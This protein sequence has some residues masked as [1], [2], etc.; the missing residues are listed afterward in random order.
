MSEDGQRRLEVAPD[1]IRVTD[2]WWSTD[3]TCLFFVSTKGD[4]HPG[5][6]RGLEVA[7]GEVR[8]VFR[9]AE[10][11]R[12][13]SMDSAN[14]WIACTRETNVSPPKLAVIDTRNGTMRT[15]T[16]LNPEFGH[17]KLNSGERISG[18]NQYGEDWFG[19]LVKPAGFEEGKRYPLIITLYRSGDSF[20]LGG[21][22][23]ENPIQVYASHGFAVLS[24][25]I[26]RNRERKSGDFDD[27]LLN[28]SSPTASLEM[29]VRSLVYAGI[30]DSTK[31]GLAGFSHG[32]EILE[33]AVS[34]SH[35]FR[36]A[37]ESGPA[38]RDPYFYDMAGTTWHE[39][40]AKWGLGGWPEG[41]SRRN[42]Q[43]LAASLRAEEIET[44]LLVNSA[45]SE[46]IASLALYTSLE[47]L[48]KPVELYIYANELH[49]KNQPKH[50]Y[51]IFER[52][53]DWFRYWLR[54]EEDSSPEKR[55]QYLRWGRLRDAWT[56]RQEQFS[57][58]QMP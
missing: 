58:P 6:I 55:E 11:L 27:Y 31:V 37:V 24:F 53:L 50:R 36:A 7:S 38:A 13:Y 17:L 41:E 2:Y 49:M 33:Y 23:D 15:L 22:G 26:G 44:P 5:E 14:Q 40:F 42:W 25:D 28:W 45:D 56:Q 48:H 43:M 47:Q 20:L 1:S 32:C 12:E 29:A 46:F 34:H 57:H 4:G 8:E 21:T 51:E 39:L 9:P 35:A 16:D 18:V 52:N 10:V 30:V 54:D 19:Q 3:G